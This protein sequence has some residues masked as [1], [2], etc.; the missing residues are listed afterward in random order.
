[1][2]RTWWLVLL[3]ACNPSSDDSTDSTGGDDAEAAYCEEESRVQMLDLTLAAEGFEYTAETANLEFQGVRQG[4][5]ATWQPQWIPESTYAVHD[6]LVDPDPSG[7]APGE[8]TSCPPF[9]EAGYNAQL[10]ATGFNEQFQLVLEQYG[11][12]DQ[13]FTARIALADVDGS[14][15]PAFDSTQFAFTDLVIQGQHHDNSRTTLTLTWHGHDEALEPTSPELGVGTIE[16]AGSY[17]V[18][19]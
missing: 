3:V 2:Q 16:A 13:R 4:G 12:F 15:T 14:A 19:R 5:G 1:M 11:V 18:G 7:T 9:Y 8:P 10:T 6:T 17:D